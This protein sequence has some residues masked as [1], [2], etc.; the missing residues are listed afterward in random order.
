MCSFS[1]GNP[2]AWL[3]RHH[4]DI[5]DLRNKF[6]LYDVYVDQCMYGLRSPPLSEQREKANLH[7]HNYQVASLIN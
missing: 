4:P 6:F 2:W 7:S 3:L 5:V 1:L